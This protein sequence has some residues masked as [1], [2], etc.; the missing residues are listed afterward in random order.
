[1]QSHQALEEQLQ[2][3]FPHQSASASLWQGLHNAVFSVLLRAGE[4][5]LA[6]Q[7]G[8]AYQFETNL[9]TQLAVLL[10]LKQQIWSYSAALSGAAFPQGSACW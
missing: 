6:S 5:M 4:P 8:L 3:H 1:M 10:P 2:K 7:S 9:P